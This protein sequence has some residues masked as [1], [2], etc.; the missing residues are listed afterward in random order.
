L[1]EAVGRT[2]SHLAEGRALDLRLL[3]QPARELESVAAVLRQVNVHC[4]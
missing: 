4:A 1:P 2:F 3:L